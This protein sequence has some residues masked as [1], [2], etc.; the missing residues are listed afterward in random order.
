[1][2]YGDTTFPPDSDKMSLLLWTS[3]VYELFLEAQLLW[4]S[5]HDVAGCWSQEKHECEMIYIWSHFM[6]K[7]TGDFTTGQFMIF[8][9]YILMN[10]L[11]TRIIFSR[12]HLLLSNI[13]RS[14]RCLHIIILLLLFI[15]DTNE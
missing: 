3:V 10:L 11:R 7:N 15:I 5:S 8:T 12:S 9:F 13:N 4:I 6:Y 2:K 1:M 14:V